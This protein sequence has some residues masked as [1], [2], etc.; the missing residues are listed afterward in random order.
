MGRTYSSI[1]F[2]TFLL[3]WKGESC[4]AGTPDVV[5]QVLEPTRNVMARHAG[6]ARFDGVGDFRDRVE[7]QLPNLTSDVRFTQGETLTDDPPFLAFVR[8]HVDAQ[9]LQIH[10]PPLGPIE[11]RRFQGLGPHHGAVDFL[12][13]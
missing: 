6:S 3:N 12:P 13:G 2:S 11:D 9:T 5:Q 7:I 4:L 1:A 10:T 8:V